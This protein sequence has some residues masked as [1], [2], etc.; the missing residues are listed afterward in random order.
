MKNLSLR[1]LFLVLSSLISL[2]SFTNPQF[3]LKIA[4]NNRYLT[5]QNNVPFYWL[6]DTE[7]DIFRDF[8]LTDAEALLEDRAEKGFSVI[9][10]MIF[11]V[12][13]GTRP[14]L[15]GEKPFIKDDPEK[16]NEAF[17]K[18]VDSVV[19]IADK[20]GLI[21]VLGI[22]HKSDDYGRLITI[23]NARTWARW[24]GQRYKNN[25]N[26]I[27]SMF[28]SANDSYVPIVR[29]LA[30]GLMEG[31][32]AAHLIT[33]H[34][35]PA[36][37]SSS[38]IHN[39]SWLS[40][41]TI[42]TW[43]SDFINYTMVADDYSKSPVKP[44]INGEARYED[45]AGTIPLQVRNGAYW[46]CLAGGFYSYGHGGNWMSPGKW[47]TW[48]DSPS[49]GD[50]KILGEVFRSLE[51][52]KLEP[53]Q[54]VISGE[55]GQKVVARSSDGTWIISYL[56]GK[57]RIDINMDKIISIGLISAVWINPATGDRTVI[58]KFNNSGIQTFTV[59]EEW[60]DA[61]LLLEGAGSIPIT[62]RLAISKNKRY[63]VNEKDDP[64][65]IQRGAEGKSISPLFLSLQ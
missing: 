37:A 57:G 46:S 54:S 59:P 10:T 20:K 47:R 33:V 5:D 18:F 36:Q 39:E 29:E 30:A 28:P 56:P 12:S 53:D 9:Q 48:I 41:N 61:L 11:G 7:W 42:Q 24:I 17:F 4:E 38:W 58:G 3:P 22:Y 2:P 15:M 34:P 27:W 65:L 63:F 19:E 14:N 31:D 6:G 62:S 40:F 35:D 26:I 60:N 13:G 43:K 8:T 44:V 1:L 52:W 16:P 25:K 49:A 45:E 55:T 21:V 23:K 51:W 64:V 50:M 32:G